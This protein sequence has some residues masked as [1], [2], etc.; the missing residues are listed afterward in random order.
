[1]ERE[2]QSYGIQEDGTVAFPGGKG[3]KKNSLQ[4]DDEEW[5]KLLAEEIDRE[6]LEEMAALAVPRRPDGPE[7][8]EAL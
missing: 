8:P 5:G 2:E 4:S 7:G 3:M 1:M 6:I